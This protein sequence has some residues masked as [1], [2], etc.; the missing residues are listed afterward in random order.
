MFNIKLT[1]NILQQSAQFAM[2]NNIGIRGHGDGNK[3]EQLVGII[4]QNLILDKLN[5]PLM[6]QSGFDG[7]VDIVLNNT[8]LDIKTMGR[9]VYPKENYVNNLIGMQINYDVDGYIFCSYHKRDDVLTVCGWIDKESFLNKA[10][11]YREGTPRTRFDGTQFIAKCDLYEIEN[12]DLIPINNIKELS[13]V[14]SILI[15]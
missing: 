4:G 11:F 12:K 1:E 6:K 2:E 8:K 10:K 9:T 13:E 15:Q 14:G 7:G 3:E 5:K